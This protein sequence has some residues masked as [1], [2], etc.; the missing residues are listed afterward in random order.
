MDYKEIYMSLEISEY[1]LKAIV[2]EYFNSK[3]NILAAHEIILKQ[4]LEKEDVV[5]ELRKLKDNIASK[6]GYPIENTILIIPSIHCKKFKDSVKVDINN[7]HHVV[8]KEEV[9][10]GI[11]ELI[12]KN[13][14]SDDFVVNVSVDKYMAYGFGFVSNPVGLETRYINME[15]SIYTI[16]SIIAYPFIKVAEQAGFNI[17]DVCLDIIALQNFA[18]TSQSNNIGAVIV[19]LNATNTKLAHFKNGSLKATSIIDIG[20]NNITNDI[21]ICANIDFEK[22]ETFKKKYVNLDLAKINDIIIYSWHDEINDEQIKI[23]QKFISEVSKARIV[24]LLS[25]INDELKRY[26][27]GNDELIYFCSGGSLI[28]GLDKIMEECLDYRPIIMK[29][30]FIGAR[31]SGYQKCIGSIINEAKF[32]RIRGEIKLYVNKNDYNESLKLVSENNL[33]YNMNS[34]V[35]ND[36]IKRL[37]SYIFN[38]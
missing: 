38:N 28:N 29:K 26:E 16:P 18:L 33:L 5:E 21:A 37:V 24:E 17:V 35:S 3:I 8:T 23:T 32:S 34:N 14:T 4:G 22:A 9:A 13:D 7:D 30:E 12:S 20:G 27:L 11:K 19:D 2:A 36:F 10:L 15:A 31:Y 25:L 1:S 6:L